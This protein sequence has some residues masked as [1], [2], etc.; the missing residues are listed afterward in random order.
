METVNTS[1]RLALFFKEVEELDTRTKGLKRRR[2]A[3]FIVDNKTPDE[4]T[5]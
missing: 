5:G 4:N 2:I 3:L 1:M